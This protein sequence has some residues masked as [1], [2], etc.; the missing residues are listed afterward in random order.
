MSRERLADRRRCETF[1]FEHVTPGGYSQFYT[2]SVGYYEDGSV[3]EVF[4]SRGHSGTDVDIAIRDSAIALSLALQHGCPLELA[5]AAF[6]RREGGAADGPLGTL[7]N[8]LVLD[9][10]NG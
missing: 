5:S 10:R 3:G 8:I 6:L 2:A 7:V 1:V 9:G 4:I